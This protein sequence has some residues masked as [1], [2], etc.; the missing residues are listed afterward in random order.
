MRWLQVAWKSEKRHSI[1]EIALSATVTVPIQ[2][3]G[4]SEREKSKCCSFFRFLL[5]SRLIAFLRII[6]DEFESAASYFR[7]AISRQ[8]LLTFLRRHGR[9]GYS[10]R[11][12]MCFLSSSFQKTFFSSSGLGPAA[13]RLLMF[14]IFCAFNE[15]D[16]SRNSSALFK[17]TEFILKLLLSGFSISAFWLISILTAS[18]IFLPVLSI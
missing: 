11:S 10:Q 13:M 18:N 8:S 5:G 2:E 6:A 7:F 12:C 9:Q 14:L 15:L 16:F 17:S 4:D 3:H 1:L